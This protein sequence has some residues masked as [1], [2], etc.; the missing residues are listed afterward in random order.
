VDKP[1]EQQF[2]DAVLKDPVIT[3]ATKNW[4]KLKQPKSF[5][6]E[7]ILKRIIEHHVRIYGYAM[8]NI[9]FGTN[10]IGSGHFDW[11]KNELA[12]DPLEGGFGLPR[13]VFGTVAHEATHAYHDALADALAAGRI[14]PSD[15]R[16][17]LA[18]IMRYNRMFYTELLDSD[19]NYNPVD[20]A[21]EPLEK[22]AEAFANRLREALRAKWLAE[23]GGK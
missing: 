10:D 2:F 16:Y 23:S 21:R 6:R 15:P 20:Y 22:E 17:P 18:E 9:R 19:K 8:P 3:E 4:P 12:I 11:D 13:S 14:Q 7:E 5:A 1:L